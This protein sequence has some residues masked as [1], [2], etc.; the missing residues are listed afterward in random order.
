M[1]FTHQNDPTKLQIADKDRI[2]SAFDAHF[3][4]VY[5]F[6]NY[7]LSHPDA[8]EEIASEVFIRLAD[9]T[10]KGKY[11]AEN[12]KGWLFVTASHLIGDHFRA[13]YKNKDSDL[14]DD[15][16]DHK[17]D[18][19]RQ[20]EHSET[21]SLLAE[22]LSQLTEDQQQVINYRFNLEYSIEETAKIMSKNENAI[23]QL[24]FRALSN[25]KKLM[26]ETK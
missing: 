25:L 9:S 18:L 4:D 17:T 13:L 19:Q 11:P 16:A 12:L 10:K 2:N 21:R 1:P 23:K 15:L 20:Y 7:R 5:R 6:V 26:S 22:S 8:A 3:N 14:S 24:Q